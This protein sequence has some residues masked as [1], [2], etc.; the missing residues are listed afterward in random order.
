MRWWGRSCRA[1][2]GPRRRCS[3]R[4]SEPS[5]GA[6]LASRLDPTGGTTNKWK[7]RNTRNERHGVLALI[8]VVRPFRVFAVST[9]WNYEHAKEKKSAKEPQN[10]GQFFREFRG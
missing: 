9:G 8:R 1:R 5:S 2:R 6:R 3:T 4:C 7:T 10:R